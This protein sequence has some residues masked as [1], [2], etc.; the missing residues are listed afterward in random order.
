[1]RRI[2]N[3]TRYLTDKKRLANLE[4]WRRKKNSFNKRP[5]GV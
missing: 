4:K 1:M 2:A 5:V 3:L